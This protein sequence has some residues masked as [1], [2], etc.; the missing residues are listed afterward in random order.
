[1]LKLIDKN[2]DILNSKDY[3]RTLRAE[4]T[5]DEFLL[6][7]Y[8]AYNHKDYNTHEKKFKT[9][10]EKTCFFHSLHKP[11]LDINPE[12][13]KHFDLYERSAFEN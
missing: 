5:Q 1:M 3:L 8:H 4:F 12:T 9:L 10:I 7:Y 11:L 6:I 2:N 13:N